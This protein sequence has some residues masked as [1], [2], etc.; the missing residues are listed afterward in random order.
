[1]TNKTIIAKDMRLNGH[2]CDLNHIDI[3]RIVDMRN[4]FFKLKFNGNIS[5]WNVSHVKNMGY[6]F[7]YSDFNGDI[8]KWD[9]SNVENMSA[10]FHNSQFNGD[11]SQ[12][13]VSSVN[14]MRYL[15]Y[16]SLFNQDIS[17]WNVSCVETMSHMFN[18]SQF[19]G[20]ISHWKPYQ[21]TDVRTLFL[22]IKNPQIPYW[23]AYDDKD[24]RK[25][26]IDAY[27]LNKQLEETLE[28]KLSSSTN[29]KKVKL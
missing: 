8:S 19:N 2:N 7:D 28:E 14:N 12:W 5:G 11:I 21:A 15:F 9:V 4:L 6:M 20:D 24:E 22:N 10:M 17:K 23:L 3:S 1:M 29:E 26:A 16:D 25:K 18:A 27:R 13:N